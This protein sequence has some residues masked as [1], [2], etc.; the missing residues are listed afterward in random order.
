MA[1]AEPRPGRDGNSAFGFDNDNN[2]TIP[3]YLYLPATI[4]SSAAGQR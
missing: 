4:C 3:T 2:N 1:T